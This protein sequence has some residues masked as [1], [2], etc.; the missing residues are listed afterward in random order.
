MA[1]PA[2]RRPAGTPVAHRDPV[3]TRQRILTAAIA[4]FAAKGLSGARI[5]EIARRAGANKRML[6]HY[7]GHKED[8]YLA[9]LETVYESIRA[10]ERELRLEHQP[11]EEAMRALVRFT[12]QYFIEHPEFISLLNNENLHEAR[13]LRRSGR[14]RDLHSPLVALIGDVLRRG[15]AAGTF[16]AGVD[17]VQLYISIASLGYFYLAN[18]HTL[19]TIFARDLMAPEE[20]A[21]RREHIVEVVLGYLRS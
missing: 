9:A 1:R 7:F 15:V 19:S 14:V 10:S 5:D 17:P 20:L 16:R 2:E 13:H 11:P 4:E 6:Y 8:L 21:T 3:R 18:R 12:W